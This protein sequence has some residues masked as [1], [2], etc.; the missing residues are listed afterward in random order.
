MANGWQPLTH[1]C[2]RLPNSCTNDMELTDI[3][4]REQQHVD[5]CASVDA[6]RTLYGE[7]TFYPEIDDQ[8]DG[9]FNVLQFYE[10]NAQADRVQGLPDVVRNGFLDRL[11]RLLGVRNI[12]AV[13]NKD[14]IHLRY[15]LQYHGDLILGPSGSIQS[16]GGKPA[17][18]DCMTR[19]GLLCCWGVASARANCIQERIISPR[20]VLLKGLDFMYFNLLDTFSVDTRTPPLIRMTRDVEQIRDFMR[21]TGLPHSLK[22]EY[23]LR[24]SERISLL[25]NS[26]ELMEQGEMACSEDDE[27]A[28]SEDDEDE[29]GRD[30]DSELE[31]S[32]EIE[33]TEDETEHVTEVIPHTEGNSAAEGGGDAVTV[34]PAGPSTSAR[35]LPK[36]SD[37]SIPEIRREF[38][39]IPD[40][41]Y[42]TA[43]FFYRY[44]KAESLIDYPDSIKLESLSGMDG[45]RRP[46]IGSRVDNVIIVLA[47]LY[48]AWAEP[49]P[50]VRTRA[51]L[52]HMA[53]GM[54]G[55][56]PDAT[57]KAMKESADLGHL[58]AICAADAVS[59]GQEGT[60][61]NEQD[62]YED[63]DEE[64]DYDDEPASKRQRQ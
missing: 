34:M 63:E 20:P 10:S 1:M 59:P 60:V 16:K 48:D 26:R 4:E 53:E 62:E 24:A 17:A 56:I 35:L 52:Q 27:D 58:H 47:K 54:K 9:P 39:C 23:G 18:G 55:C 45:A 44:K 19:E 12:H 31:Y 7:L 41:Y 42:N 29:V 51:V 11:G 32:H 30:E 3:D 8:G 33:D 50:G 13:Q 37:P 40:E 49:S 43:P 64:D 21:N 57:Y 28:E 38:S 14:V 15:M 61:A 46:F 6:T 22:K 25:V 36:K 5:L 2:T